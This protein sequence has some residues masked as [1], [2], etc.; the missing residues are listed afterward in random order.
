MKFKEEMAR[1]DSPSI[2]A[3]LG[4]GCLGAIKIVDESDEAIHPEYRELSAEEVCWNAR[5]DGKS[6]ENIL[7]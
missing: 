3:G 1:S 7:R 6:Y 2:L 5:A 4:R